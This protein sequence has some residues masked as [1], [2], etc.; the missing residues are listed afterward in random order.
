MILPQ[1]LAQEKQLTKTKSTKAKGKGIRPKKK[2]RRSE[3]RA[4]EIPRVI[5]REMWKVHK[6]RQQR[7]KGSQNRGISRQ[8]R[9]EEYRQ[10]WK[11]KHGE[12]WFE[13]ENNFDKNGGKAKK[14]QK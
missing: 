2:H 9:G 11:E 6:V 13:K 8:D 14:G 7:W 10:I 12:K 3:A 1:E 5:P 4:R